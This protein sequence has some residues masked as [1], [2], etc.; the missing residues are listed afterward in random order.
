M[1]I[2]I[3]IILVNSNVAKFSPYFLV[4][5]KL[6][7]VFSKIIDIF[8]VVSQFYYL[9]LMLNIL[10]E[11]NLLCSVKALSLEIRLSKLGRC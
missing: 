2:T 5:L 3:K 8:N 10:F 6:K 9:E 11:I 4:N 1:R 7:S